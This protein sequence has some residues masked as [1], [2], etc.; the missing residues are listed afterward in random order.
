M[1]DETEGSSCRCPRVR[2]GLELSESR[3]WNPDRAEHGTGSPWW[4]SDA[5]QA[6]RSV[7]STR[8]RKLA[9]LAR[10]SR[11]ARDAGD[12]EM[13]GAIQRHAREL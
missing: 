13:L 10:A 7:E 5:E 1:T 9:D 8:L 12:A 4:N 3:N 2:V 6:K 11:R